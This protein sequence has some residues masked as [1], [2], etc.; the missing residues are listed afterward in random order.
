MSASTTTITA[1]S[2]A[3]TA[4]T[5]ATLLEETELER[6]IHLLQLS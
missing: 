3:T 5:T 2:S 4:I 1:M 6:K